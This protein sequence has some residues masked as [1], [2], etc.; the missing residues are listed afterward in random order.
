MKCKN[1]DVK[2]HGCR[3]SS[4]DIPACSKH[5]SGVRSGAWHVLDP[6]LFSIALNPGFPS[7]KQKSV[8]PPRFSLPP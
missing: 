6:I 3:T 2:A 5:V 1:N 7:P 8:S 4:G